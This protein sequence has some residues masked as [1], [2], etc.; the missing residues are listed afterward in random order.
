MAQRSLPMVLNDLICFS[1]NISK[2]IAAK[3]IFSR[4]H[5]SFA[6]GWMT[7]ALASILPEDVEL[8]QFKNVKISSCVFYS[9]RL[10]TALLLNFVS[11][12]TYV[13]ELLNQKHKTLSEFCD[14]AFC[15]YWPSVVY[16]SPKH[17]DC[18]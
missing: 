8:R 10:L 11:V 16:C 2:I 5:D 14:H 18:I 4:G 9:F 13:S 12:A 1:I 17:K 7:I 6:V 15:F 3:A